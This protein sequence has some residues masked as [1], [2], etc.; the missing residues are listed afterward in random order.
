MFAESSAASRA[1]AAEVGGGHHNRAES[2]V[3]RS[4]KNFRELCLPLACYL[5]PL[6]CLHLTLISVHKQ[7]H[8]ARSESDLLRVKFSGVAAKTAQNRTGVLCMG[9]AAA[10]TAVRCS[11]LAACAAAV[12]VSLILYT[13]IFICA[14][15]F[16]RWPP[17]NNMRNGAHHPVVRCGEMGLMAQRGALTLLPFAGNAFSLHV[18]AGVCLFVQ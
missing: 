16:Y 15:Y 9:A 4:L 5:F 10:A 3:A 13:R 11:L 14:F 7:V 18:R 6:F 17:R 12:R 8:G 1:R 2:S